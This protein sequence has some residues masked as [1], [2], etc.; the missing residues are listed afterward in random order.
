M[1]FLP[2]AATRDNCCRSK[3]A[4]SLKVLRSPRDKSHIIVP[5]L[6][7]ITCASL[8]RNLC[9]ITMKNASNRCDRS[10]TLRQTRLSTDHLKHYSPSSNSS[11]LFH[12]PGETTNTN[13]RETHIQNGRHRVFGTLKFGSK[14]TIFATFQINFINLVALFKVLPIF[15]IFLI[16]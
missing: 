1:R 16:R 15:R 5:N 8:T 6:S 12:R 4:A 9:A 7:R 14:V 13:W 10:R 11:L 3:V 2:V